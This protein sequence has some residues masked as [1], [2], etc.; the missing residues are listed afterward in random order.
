MHSLIIA[1]HQGELYTEKGWGKNR[2]ICIG[3]E[4]ARKGEGYTEKADS[5]PLDIVGEVLSCEDD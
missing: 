1:L 5:M 4:I 2:L 3:L